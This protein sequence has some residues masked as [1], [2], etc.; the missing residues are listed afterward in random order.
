M[1]ADPPEPVLSDDEGEMKDAPPPP[2]SG[3]EEDVPKQ[4]PPQELPPPKIPEA[5]EG[6]SGETAPSAPSLSLEQRKKRRAAA[7]EK[8]KEEGR[9]LLNRV[10]LSNRLVR[11]MKADD[12][13]PS[14]MRGMPSSRRRKNN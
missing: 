8:K 12:N 4:P 1:E 10:G 13:A 5:F 14:I 11:V 7:L 2:P 6:T 3:M 9:D